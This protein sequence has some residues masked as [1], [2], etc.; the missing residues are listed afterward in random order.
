MA[1]SE[2]TKKVLV[3]VE[4]SKITDGML[5]FAVKQL[6]RPTD[7]LLLLNV[8]RGAPLAG[9]E[10]VFSVS[11]NA[12]VWDRKEQATSTALLE[13]VEAKAHEAGVTSVKVVSA[14][15]DPREVIVHM[16]REHQA[17]V[18][19]VGDKSAHGTASRMKHMLGSVSDYCTHHS[20]CPVLVYRAPVAAQ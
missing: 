20:P 17:D 16:A 2:A 5:E 10:Q 11:H 3:A 1:A 6:V 12:S 4:E 13:S 15:G 7:S 18:L 9:S 19:V 8:R 14:S